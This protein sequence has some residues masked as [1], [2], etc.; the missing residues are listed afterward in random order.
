VLP[1]THIHCRGRGPQEGKGMERKVVRGMERTGK[2][3]KGRVQG[4]S[5]KR[6][7]G[8]IEAGYHSLLEDSQK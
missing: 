8:R 3:G 6:R 5:G 2:E 1:W 7:Q 4:K